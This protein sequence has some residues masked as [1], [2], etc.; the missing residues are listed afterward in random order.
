MN[1]YLDL[2]LLARWPMSATGREIAKVSEYE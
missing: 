1:E 2:G